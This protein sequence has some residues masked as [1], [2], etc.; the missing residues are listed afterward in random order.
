MAKMNE[1]DIAAEKSLE[2]QNILYTRKEN[3]FLS[4]LFLLL[5]FGALFLFIVLPKREYSPKENK[6][7]A[8]FPVFEMSALA[9]GSFTE[10]MV[11]YIGDHFPFR[12]QLVEMNALYQLTLGKLGNSGVIIGK[13]GYLLTE[14]HYATEK[15]R[16]QLARYERLISVFSQKVPTVVAVAGKGS[17]VM[18]EK[19]PGIFSTDAVLANRKLVNDAFEGKHYTYL[20]LAE[21]LSAHAGEDIYYRTDHHWTALGAYYGSAAVLETFGKK[22]MEPGDF[23]VEKAS[24]NFRGTIYNR[25]GMFWHKGEELVYFRYDGDESYKIA[26]C[27]ARGE[28]FDSSESLYDRSCLTKNH[29]GTAYDSYVA[30]VS[31]PVVKITGQGEDRETLLVLKDSF[32]H[33]ALPFLA[34]EYNV[35]TVD[36]RA[37][38]DY[39]AQLIESG[40]VDALLVL[41]NSETLL[42]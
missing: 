12:D 18:T 37:N 33:A 13:D 30:P 16:E 2:K 5:L 20:D 7:P 34:R 35:I 9:D 31:T 32:A 39:A 11:K 28:E 27:T 6:E 23:E 25:S 21:V 8:H 40:E 14:E 26:F 15:N 36:I 41:V 4:A 38:A 29:R 17:E 24:E 22:T 42:G 1:A 19:F 10:G 3:I